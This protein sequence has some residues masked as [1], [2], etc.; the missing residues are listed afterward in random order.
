MLA[1]CSSQLLSQ[2]LVPIE[3]GNVSFKTEDPSCRTDTIHSVCYQVHCACL[4][5]NNW[6]STRHGFS[7][8][9]V[10]ARIFRIF[11]RNKAICLSKQFTVAVK[12]IVLYKLFTLSLEILQAHI[13]VKKQQKANQA[14]FLESSFPIHFFL[15]LSHPCES[16]LEREAP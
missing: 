4:C 14:S 16:L 2:L 11:S 8:R 3:A 10:P 5:R 6:Q 12:R 15:V 9:I 13:G 7:Y 1:G